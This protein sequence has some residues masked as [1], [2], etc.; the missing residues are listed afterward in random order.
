M[1]QKCQ[2]DMGQNCQIIL[3]QNCQIDMGENYQTKIGKNVKIVLNFLDKKWT[4]DILC[5][6]SSIDLLLMS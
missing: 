1:G 6:F 3:D 4:F 5:P 2:I